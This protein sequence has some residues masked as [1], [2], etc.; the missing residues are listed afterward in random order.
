MAR[1][2][3]HLDGTEHSGSP[4]ATAPAASVVVRRPAPLQPSLVD[5]RIL[6]IAAVVGSGAAFR[7]TQGLLSVDEMLTRYVV[8][9]LGC[10]AAS[11]LVRVLWPVL[12]GETA[13][14]EIATDLETA[15][16]AA[17]LEGVDLDGLSE[18]AALDADNPFA[19]SD[20]FAADPF[21]TE[22][23]GLDSFGF[24]FNDEADDTTRLG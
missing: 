23:T 21:A 6:V 22:P 19:T 11:V 13:Q 4:S 15:A 16:A 1:K 3:R 14:G 7:V 2:H 10:V 17:G 18:L 12:S 5:A 8:V 9:A 24:G 20:P